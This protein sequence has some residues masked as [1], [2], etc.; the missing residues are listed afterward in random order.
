MIEPPPRASIPGKVALQMR[1]MEVTF[2]SHDAPQSSSSQLRI[3][4]WWT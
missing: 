1:N 2:T 3:E 4:P